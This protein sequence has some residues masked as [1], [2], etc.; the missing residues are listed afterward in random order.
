MVICLERKTKTWLDKVVIQ[1]THHCDIQCFFFGWLG[2]TDGYVIML[3]EVA[4]RGYVSLCH[5]GSL[6]SSAII[7]IKLVTVTPTVKAGEELR[8]YNLSHLKLQYS[9][10]IK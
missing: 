1:K 2:Q 6:L 5:H 3:A 7:T 4:L 10:I 9:P 8:D